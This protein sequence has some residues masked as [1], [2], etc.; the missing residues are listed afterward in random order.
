VVRPRRKQCFARLRDR[1]I[2]A[3][4]FERASAGAAFAG[5]PIPPDLLSPAWFLLP[6]PP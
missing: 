1:L 5:S 2:G 3:P 6:D 4:C